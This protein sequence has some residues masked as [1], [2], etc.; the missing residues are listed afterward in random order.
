MT[1]PMQA[2]FFMF[3]REPFDR[4]PPRC[5]FVTGPRGAGKTR[6]MQERIRALRAE[7][8]EGRCGVVLAE[9]GRTRMERFAQEPPGVAV[10][11][12]FLPC[13]CCPALADLTGGLRQLVADARTDWLFLEVPS[14][15]AAGLLAEFDRAIGWPRQLVVCQGAASAEAPRR[16]DPAPFFSN[17][18]DLADSV[19]PGPAP[20]SF[21]RDAG[22]RREIGPDH[23]PT[24]CLS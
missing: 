22:R 16:P 6:W 18:L 19:V 5:V 15:A 17:L 14:I 21:L 12:V 3:A 8:P 9:E 2:G 11:R 20:T 23:L 1:A 4:P 10:R 24:I 7:Q 13:L